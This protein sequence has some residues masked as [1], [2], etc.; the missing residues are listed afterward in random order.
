VIGLTY[1]TSSDSLRK[2]I[3]EI[4]SYINNHEGTSDDG[5]ASFKSFGDSGLNVEVNYFVT[6]LN[7][8]EFLKIRQEINLEI[9]DIVIRNKSD[10]AYPTQRLISDRPLGNA[11]EKEVG[12]DATD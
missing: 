1:E 11:T 6:V 4:E 9:M 12:N 3:T 7:Y 10:F 8:T 2:I 5:N